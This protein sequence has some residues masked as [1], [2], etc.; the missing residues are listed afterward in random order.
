MVGTATDGG[1]VPID[2]VVVVSVA[3]AEVVVVAFVSMSKL[4]EQIPKIVIVITEGF[5]RS[6]TANGRSN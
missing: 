1:R 5:R 3:E 2:K 6:E 4:V